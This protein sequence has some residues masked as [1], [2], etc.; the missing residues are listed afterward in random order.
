MVYEHEKRD[1]MLMSMTGYQD[2]VWHKAEAHI[3]LDVGVPVYFE[4]RM[5][6]ITDS[7][8]TFHIDDLTF[9]N[10]SEF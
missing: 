8:P 3:N 10:C 9:H 5:T 2:N 7:R 1:V 4:M 6:E